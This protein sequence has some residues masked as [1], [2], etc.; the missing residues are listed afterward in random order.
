MIITKAGNKYVITDTS[1]NFYASTYSSYDAHLISLIPEMQHFV[2]EVASH[3]DG[4]PTMMIRHFE[5][6]LTKLLKEINS[7][8]DL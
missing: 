8:C 6:I 3:I 2:M 4:H 1:G 5:S 7:P